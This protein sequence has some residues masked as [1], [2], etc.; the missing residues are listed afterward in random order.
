MNILKY[1]NIYNINNI[2]YNLSYDD[3]FELEKKETGILTNLNTMC[4]KT[5]RVIVYYKKKERNIIM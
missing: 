2:F 5:G 3:I 1:Y 4:I